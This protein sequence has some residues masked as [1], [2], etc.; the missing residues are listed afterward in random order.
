[1]PSTATKATD[2]TTLCHLTGNISAKNYPVSMKI[3]DSKTGEVIQEIETDNQGNYSTLLPKGDYKIVADSNGESLIT[4]IQLEPNDTDKNLVLQQGALISGTVYDDEGNPIAN[5]K[6]VIETPKGNIELTTDQQGNYYT[7]AIEDGKYQSYIY[8]TQGIPQS[9]AT[10]VEVKQGQMTTASGTELKPGLITKGEIVA[11][12]NGDG[13]LD[14]IQNGKVELIDKNGKIFE[15]T[16]DANGSYILPSVAPGTYQLKVTDSK[17]G[18]VIERT[19]QIG[20]DNSTALGTTPEK[21]DGTVEINAEKFIQN[22]LTDANQN[23]ITKST[24]ENY[25]IILD[26]QDAWNELTQQEKDETN[27]IL[28]NKYN[29]LTYPELLKQ[30]ESIQTQV[31]NFIKDHMSL[32]D[33]TI[34]EVNKDTY[35]TIISAKDAWDKLSEDEKQAANDALK[36]AGATQTYEQMLAATKAKVNQSAIDFINKYVSDKNKNIYKEANKSNYM[37]ILSG[38]DVWSKLSESEKDAINAILIHAGSKNYEDLLKQANVVKKS[39]QTNDNT[40]I[41]PLYALLAVSLLLGS[42]I[43]GKRKK[44]ND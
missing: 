36:V 2:I 22:N 4:D 33:Q 29:G 23:V 34:T 44:E 20:N 7:D 32:N 40:N 43:I 39:V 9:T 14:P 5:A 15:T 42:Y 13:K 30:A 28:V 3:L 38:S 16:T 17:T 8:T 19:I 6:V 24:G 10:T 35:A 26:A 21:I 37:Q 1:M 41:V 18:A 27:K 11:D 25:K 31:Q 12:T